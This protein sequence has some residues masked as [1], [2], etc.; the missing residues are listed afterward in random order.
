MAEKVSVVIE[1]DS[2]GAVRAFQ[3]AGEAARGFGDSAKTAGTSVDAIGRSAGAAQSSV[4]GVGAASREAAGGM[5]SLGAAA[6]EN[7][8]VFGRLANALGVSKTMLAGVVTGVLGAVGAYSAAKTALEGFMGVVDR[9]GALD[10][11]SQKIGVASSTLSQFELAAQTTGTSLEGIGTGIKILS[12]NLTEAAAG[13]SDSANALKS[14]FT[15]MGVDVTAALTDTNGAMLA[16]ADTFAEMPDGAQKTA[17]AMELFGKAGT[18]IIPFLN[19]GSE[20][21]KEMTRLNDQLGLSLSGP[22]IS[23][24]DNFGDKLQILG[25]VGTGV[26]TQIAAGAAPILSRM[27]SLLVDVAAQAGI[28]SG[29]LQSFGQTLATTVVNAIASVMGAIGQ[30]LVDLGNA[31]I[32]QAIVNAFSSGLSAV[33]ALAASAMASVKASIYDALSVL[34]L[35]GSSYA[36]AASSMRASAEGYLSAVTQI[37]A[38][39]EAI[40][41]TGQ[42]LLDTAESLRGVASEAS[43]TGGAMISLADGSDQASQGTAVITSSA[44]NASAA[45]GLLKGAGDG[46]ATSTQATGAAATG[47]AGGVD[48][49]TQAMQSLSGEFEKLEAVGNIYQQ[50]IDG[51]VDYQNMLINLNAVQSLSNDI[52]GDSE[53]RYNAAVVAYEKNRN[54]ILAT[55]AELINKNAAT[56]TEVAALSDAVA[57]GQGYEEG[58]R[59]AAVALI[60]YEANQQLAIGTSE[61]LVARMT[62]EKIV[63]LDAAKAKEQNSAAL[64]TNDAIAGLN[65]E[66]ALWE[67]VKSGVISVNDAQREL[68]VQQK[69]TE[70][71]SRALA[72]SY[73]DAGEKAKQSAESA[74]NSFISLGSTITG[75]FEQTFDAIV[76]GTRDLGDALAGIGLSIGKQIFSAMLKSKT[77]YFDVEVKANFLDLGDFGT[78]T[79]ANVF[80]D[81]ASFVGGLFGFGGGG[82][83][84]PSAPIGQN[85]DGTYIYPNGSGEPIGQ[86]SDGSYMFANSAAGAIGGAAQMVGGINAMT[87]TATSSLGSFAGALGAVAGAASIAAAVLPLLIPILEKIFDTTTKGTK[88]RREGEG[89]FESTPEVARLTEPNRLGDLTRD[90]GDPKKM[91]PEFVVEGPNYMTGRDTAVSRG[92]TR[93]QADI[94]AGGSAGIFTFLFGDKADSEMANGAKDMGNMIAEW[95]SRGMADGMSFEEVM[96]LIHGFAEDAGVTLNDAMRGVAKFGEVASSVWKDSTGPEEFARNLLGVS[97]VFQQDVPQGVNI[98]AIALQSMSKDGESAFKTLDQGTKD[99]LVSLADSPEQFIAAVSKLNAQGFNIDLT[100]FKASLADATA[101]AEAIG[102]ALAGI[103]NGGDVDSAIS[104]MTSKLSTDVM[105]AFQEASLGDLFDT[106]AIAE[107]FSPVYEVLRNLKEGMYDV[108]SEG[109]MDSFMSSLTTAVAEGKAN[110]DEYIPRLK[111]MKAAADE[112]QKALDEAFAPTPDE[113]AWARLAQT[114]EQAK[115]QVGTALSSG[116]SSAF[117]KIGEGGSV[118]EATAAFSENFKKS[119]ASSVLQGLQEAMVQSAVMEG[120]LGGLMAEFKTATAAALADGVLT[121]AEQAQL[122]GLAAQIK[123]VGDQTA[124]ALE[125]LVAS[126]ATIGTNVVGTAGAVTTAGQDVVFNANATA[127]TVTTAATTTAT[128]IA[129][130]TTTAGETVATAVTTAATTTAQGIS[131][132]TT[133]AAETVATGTADASSQFTAVAEALSGAASEITGG[134]SGGSGELVAALSTMTAAASGIATTATG[135]TAELIAALQGM[136]S[137]ASADMAAALQEMSAAT[138]AT[139]EE[140]LAALQERASGIATAT[141]DGVITG[142]EQASLA[143]AEALAG[144]A[145]ATADG[146]MTGGEESSAAIAEALRASAGKIAE[147]SASADEVAAALQQASE[148]M[149]AGA[150]S[151]STDMTAALKKAAE[152]MSSGATTASGDMLAALQGM[153]TDTA[154]AIAS[155]SETASTEMTA[156]VGEVAAA[157]ESTGPAVAEMLASA[158]ETASTAVQSAVTANEATADSLAVAPEVAYATGEALAAMRDSVGPE[159][160]GTIDSLVASLADAKMTPEESDAIKGVMESFSGIGKEIDPEGLKQFEKVQAALVNGAGKLDDPSSFSAV[161]QAFGTATQDG[162]ANTTAVIQAFAEVPADGL[163]SGTQAMIESF[164]TGAPELISAGVAEL[165]D[166]L[167]A[168]NLSGMTQ[169]LS[170]GLLSV[171][172][173]SNDLQS[174]LEDLSSPTEAATDGMSDLARA[175]AAAVSE[176]NNATSNIS[177]SSVPGAAVG[178]TFSSGSA[179]V[180]EAGKPELVTAMPG[181]GFRVTPLSWGQ[182]SALMGSGTPGF[183]AGGGVPPPLVDRRDDGIG[184]GGFTPSAGPYGYDPKAEDN[185]FAE[186]TDAIVEAFRAGFEGSK[187]FVEDFSDSIKESVRSRLADAIMQ[188]FSENPN[189]QKYAANIDFL[190]TKAQGL[191]GNNRLTADSL[192]E[193][194][195]EIKRNTDEITKQADQIDELLEPLRQAEAIS[196][197]ISGSLNFSGALK[198]LALNPDDLEGFRTSIDQS[199]SEAVLN[200]AI[201]GLLASGPIKDAIKDFQSTMNEAM[202]TALEDGVLTAEE[203]GSL[204][205][206]AKSGSA[207]MKTAMEALGPVLAE[208]G[209]DLGDGLTEAATRAKDVLQSASQ[210]MDPFAALDD[211]Q[212]SFKAFSQN[213]RDQVYGNIRDGMVQAFIDSAVTQGLLAGPMAA[214]QSIFDAIGQKQMTTAE[215]NIALAEQVATINGSLADPAF[216]SAFNS[217]MES[218]RNIGGQLG[219]TTKSVDKAVTTATKAVDTTQDVCKAGCE[220]QART[221]DLGDAAANTFGRNMGVSIEDFETVVPKLAMG[222]LVRRKTLAYV[223]EAG[224]ELVVP[225]T[226]IARAAGAIESVDF[227]SLARSAAEALTDGAADAAAKMKGENG[228]GILRRSDFASMIGGAAGTS[229]GSAADAAAKM[230][231]ENGGGVLKPSDFAKMINGA[232]ATLT[233]GAAEAAEALSGGASDAAAK[234][235]A[236]NGNGNDLNLAEAIRSVPTAAAGSVAPSKDVAQMTDELLKQSRATGDDTVSAIEDLQTAMKDIAKALKE[237]PA[238]TEIKIDG[239]VLIKAMTKA[240]RLARK[241][242]VEV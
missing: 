209:L 104:E 175:V 133:T 149:S 54:A 26:F 45:L 235:K 233:D 153:S 200:G 17:L 156:A 35:I 122:S 174:A 8:G 146:V 27:A 124:T 68:A 115:V 73:V 196:D 46:A 89:L 125:P 64:K 6:K 66:I 187:G 221:R 166:Q 219:Q 109:G 34:P 205:E 176:I 128:T 127:S 24:L 32:G 11:L 10:D 33:G 55:T 96:D 204:K 7:E 113:A 229:A 19:L 165:R 67:K 240:R 164:A 59:A 13:G 95:V 57:A 36:E 12:K 224:P 20:G 185:D 222:G 53:A 241:A 177:S 131:D 50:F 217:T 60:E 78:K 161:M 77:E 191:A 22:T 61:E 25:N 18:D 38:G 173:P 228:G 203:S 84:G 226:E 80:K 37:G 9:A 82:A 223:G 194:Q 98:A 180:G 16:L 202:S 40:A 159:M 100:Q 143:M 218:I 94:A 168:D 201:E 123:T 93:G 88:N 70:V 230:K 114:V 184:N 169:P 150:A 157:L 210:A 58:M 121:G 134:A 51:G 76:S 215:A 225:L 71:G 81:A 15:L 69:A 56:A 39:N 137:V 144:I 148:Q 44:S 102:P 52:V 236:S 105:A 158:S 126:V 108:G 167:S 99:W 135:S 195:D 182:A 79:F 21:I 208:L 28:S 31:G 86:N 170:E 213:I 75:A 83:M 237:Q 48:K 87:G 119:I 172:G 199:V 130:A 160:Q 101:S 197:A 155:G 106:T 211:G 138:G 3:T 41:N 62:Q 186:F 5:G 47:A 139:T 63:A 74:K 65:A 132:A 72:E 49:M 189:I 163:I 110:I 136:G 43:N 85:S 147:G 97:E 141:A 1:V 118:E 181:G 227:S 92:M 192:R 152:Q 129:D 242:G 220:L 29:A 112:V 238:Q 30:F 183:A 23:A 151:G 193:I 216:Q 206:L 234:L 179:V 103:F 190:I 91:R 120:A 188:G 231:S 214:I 142:G 178:G 107:S 111:A 14:A 171:V 116:V 212:T 42:M 207:K 90:R 145:T 4:T 154:G 162:A 198:S 232:A 239:E 117:S 2:A 140:L